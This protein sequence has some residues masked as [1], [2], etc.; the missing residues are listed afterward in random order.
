MCVYMVLDDHE[1]EDNWSMDRL[2]AKAPLYAAAMQAYH[3]Y[4]VVHGPAFDPAA[5]TPKNHWYKFRSGC[6]DVFVLDTRTER[7]REASPPRIVS[8]AQLEALKSWL[9]A[10][11][12]GVKFVVTSVPF[13][14]D[15]RRRSDDRWDGFEAQR[16]EI[17]DFIREHQ[18]RRVVF[19]SG[20][21]HCSMA[22]QLRCSTDPDFLVTSIV[23]S[24]FYWFL[25]HTSP[26]Q[27][28]L[29]G[30]LAQSGASVYTV[31]NASDVY[32]KDMFTRVS[33][34]PEEVVVKFYERKGA[35]LGE[36]TFSFR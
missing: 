10:D 14:P 1:I 19:L 3:A 13:F 23:S 2:P 7:L 18:I 25:P 28:D 33:V 4:Q 21:V 6:A 30:L 31:E 16:L 12:E 9:K 20:D 27:F 5:G 15:T 34:T 35:L 32:P 24:A 17:L 11:S 22:A 8:E 26:E 29:S 36:R